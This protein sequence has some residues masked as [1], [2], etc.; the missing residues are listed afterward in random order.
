MKEN[1]YHDNNTPD[2]AFWTSHTASMPNVSGLPGTVDDS[3][4]DSHAWVSLEQWDSPHFP[5]G[6]HPAAV[7]QP[8]PL[9]AVQHMIRTGRKK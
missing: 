7:P 9:S 8:A 3:R 2:S 1:K 6:T 5:H 4:S